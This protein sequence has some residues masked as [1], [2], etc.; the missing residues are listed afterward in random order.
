MRKSDSIIH[1]KRHKSIEGRVWKKNY[2]Y[3]YVLGKKPFEEN[4]TNVTSG[5][6]GRR[7]SIGST[8]KR[9]RWEWGGGGHSLKN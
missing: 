7:G 8:G 4:G 2:F 5:A 9:G 1:K 6:S 3:F